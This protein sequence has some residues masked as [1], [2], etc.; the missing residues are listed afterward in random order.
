[1]LFRDAIVWKTSKQNTIIMSSTE[2]ELL[3]LF[4]IVKKAIFISQ[5]LNV[6][7]LKLNELL[8]VE[9]DNSQTLRL[10]KEE[11]MKLSIKLCH[12]DIHNHWLHQEYAEQQVLFEWTPTK[13]MIA[14]GLTKMLPPQWHEAFIKLIKIDDIT[15][16]I[17]VEK[18]MKVL[19]DKIRLNKAEQPAEMVFLAYKRIKMRGIH[20]NHHLV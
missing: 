2:A 3:V 16:W 15:E 19:R 9:C 14:D 18:R 5:L 20:Q 8:V 13:N 11:F 1:M 10:V 4:Q 7:I 12:V 17:K 6:M